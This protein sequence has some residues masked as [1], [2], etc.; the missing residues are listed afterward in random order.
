MDLADLELVDAVAVHG[1]FSA[2]GA[3]LRLSQPSVSARISAVERTIG[4]VLFSR[5]S[6]G[7][8]LTVAGERY[9]G[10]VRRSLALLEEGRR[11]AVAEPAEA[12]IAVG[13]P[14]SYASALTPALADAADSCQLGLSLRAS[15]SR[16]L[17]TDLQDG[18][19]DVALVTAGIVPV[20]LTTRQALTTT[21]VALATA[22]ISASDDNHYAVH[23]WGEASEAVISQL[24]GRGTPR[25]NIAVVSPAAA[26]ISLALTRGH[27]AIVPRLT[28]EPDIAAGRLRPLELSLP[29]LTVRLDWLHRSGAPAGSVQ[30]FIDKVRIPDGRRRGARQTSRY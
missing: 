27:V 18:R 14:G 28:A 21:T 25:A 9:L 19:L 12:T 30:E 6:R 24:L 8:R 2:A 10:Y 20:G 26:A 23:N 15:H 4:M 7:A 16:D 22:Q 3:R 29:S 1:S 5:D 17:R 13:L 11:A